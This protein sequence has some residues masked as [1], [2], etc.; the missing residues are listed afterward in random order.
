MSCGGCINI[1]GRNKDKL[2]DHAISLGDTTDA[3]LCEY[4]SSIINVSIVFW[5]KDDT[6]KPHLI[7]KLL[8]DPKQVTFIVRDRDPNPQTQNQEKQSSNPQLSTVIISEVLKLN[9]LH[10]NFGD[11]SLKRYKPCTH[12]SSTVTDW[13]KFDDGEGDKRFGCRKE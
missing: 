5:E 10:N 11:N 2:L 1:C 12:T 8:S 7:A 9:C 13:Q 3:N 4:K 6:G